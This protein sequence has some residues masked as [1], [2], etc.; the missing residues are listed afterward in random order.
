MA[1]VEP[2]LRYCEAERN[3]SPHTLRNY[4]ADLKQFFAFTIAEYYAPDPA[5]AAAL[6]PAD[7]PIRE[8]DR[9]KIRAF[10]GHLSSGGASNATVA[11]K[12]ACLR[13]YFRFL[14]RENELEHNPA[15]DV[16]TPKQQRPLPDFLSEAEVTDLLQAPDATEPLGCRDRALLE[17]LYS[18]GMRAGEC[19]AL[20]L[21][22]LDLLSGLARVMGKGR[23]ERLVMLGRYAGAAVR[24]YLPVRTQLLRSGRRREH[25]IFFVSR[26]GLPLQPRD[27]QRIVKRCAAAAGITRPVHPH[28]LRHS[29]ATHMLDRGADLRY[30]QELLGHAS[31]STTQIY[32]HVTLERLQQVY[33]AA[34]PHA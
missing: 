20:A 34:H 23:K 30:V 12:L 32:T 28:T 31:L 19:A 27:I 4:A 3:L 1:A 18:T 10:L 7:V 22:Q 29:F 13:T 11:R 14:C 15:A 26:S 6:T 17:V 21:D 25:G 5:A 24:E 2:F 33:H 9:W 16:A 8:V